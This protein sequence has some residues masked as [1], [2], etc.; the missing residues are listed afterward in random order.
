M[1]NDD[2]VSNLS[3][4]GFN[5]VTISAIFRD[6]PPRGVVRFTHDHRLELCFYNFLDNGK[7]FTRVFSNSNKNDVLKQI[8][9]SLKQKGESK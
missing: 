4:L 6:E 8:A 1:N 2:F 7:D 9:F 3:Q 5:D